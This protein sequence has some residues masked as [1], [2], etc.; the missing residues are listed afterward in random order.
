[1]KRNANLHAAAPHS[2]K[3][4]GSSAAAAEAPVTQ[5]NNEKCQQLINWARVQRGKGQTA[6]EER[7]VRTDGDI[8]AH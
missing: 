5:L 6:A 2:R 3:S 7:R 8:A 1:M 4:G